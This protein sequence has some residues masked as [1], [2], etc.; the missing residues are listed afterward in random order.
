MRSAPAPG[1]ADLPVPPGFPPR[2]FVLLAGVP[3]AGKSTLLA[4][5]YGLH[6]HEEHTAIGADGERIVDSLQAR[7]RLHR[8]FG[9]LPYPLWRWT[10]HLLHLVRVAAALRGGPVIVHESG[11][12]RPVRLLL[13][14]AC[15]VRRYSVHVVVI[16]AT[17]D[18][19]LDGQ[20]ARGRLVT[21]RSHRT[22]S[23]RWARL[24]RLRQRGPG[25]FV[26]GAS[27]LLALDR[28]AAARLPRFRFA[29]EPPLPRR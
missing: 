3:G 11:T 1:C 29:A 23:R 6:G 15:R 2:S 22:H 25:A 5:M 24:R 10:V 13:A 8:V 4:R 20:R 28:S 17:P 19:A 18:E 12:R 16:D 9:R 21:R 26:P 14:L 27:T 7:R